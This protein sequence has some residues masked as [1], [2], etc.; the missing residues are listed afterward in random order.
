MS[1]D[2]SYFS[3]FLVKFLEIIAAGLA[4]AVSGYLITH[5]SGAL[6]SPAPA[7]ARAII[8]VTPSASI[9]SGSRPQPIPPISAD[10]NEQRLAPQQDGNAAIVAQCCHCGATRA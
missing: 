4:T 9:V 3:R 6:S 7:P 10:V 5:L 2:V 1:G 8:Q